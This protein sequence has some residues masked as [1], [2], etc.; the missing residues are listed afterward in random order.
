M[1][2]GT[3]VTTS[4]SNGYWPFSYPLP[5]LCLLPADRAPPG[6]GQRAVALGAGA[7]VPALQEDTRPEVVQAHDA[8]AL[9]ALSVL[10]GKTQ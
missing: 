2:S 9:R 4:G 7:H 1:L 5:L 8:G 3:C 10:L 6:F